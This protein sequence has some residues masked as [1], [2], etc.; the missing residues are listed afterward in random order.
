MPFKK[1][2]L[3]KYESLP[4]VIYGER[5]PGEIVTLTV[6]VVTW[7]GLVDRIKKYNVTVPWSM[8]SVQF[9]EPKLNQWV[10]K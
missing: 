6:R 8:S 10:T 3:L 5:S 9:Y 4:G 1:L 7:W 2:M